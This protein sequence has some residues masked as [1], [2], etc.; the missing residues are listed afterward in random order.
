MILFNIDKLNITL[1]VIQD[2]ERDIRQNK[3]LYK[4]CKESLYKVFNLISAY[5]SL[6]EDYEKKQQQESENI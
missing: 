2:I 4:D 5:K 1:Q 6:V 3:K